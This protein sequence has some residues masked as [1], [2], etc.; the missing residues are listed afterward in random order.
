VTNPGESGQCYLGAMIGKYPFA[1][2]SY[3]WYMS[4][5]EYLSRAILTVEAEWEEKLYKKASSPLPDDYHPEMDTTPLLSP[6][7]SQPYYGSYIGILQWTVELVRI[8]LTQSVL[9]MAWF[10]NAHHE[11]HMMAVL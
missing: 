3:A 1:D 8:N 5:E 6:D 10:C 2:G 7:D 4:A 11:G 9:L